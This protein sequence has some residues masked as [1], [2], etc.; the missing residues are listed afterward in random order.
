MFAFCEWKS[1]N[2]Q[3]EIKDS[4]WILI[5]N[6]MKK[7][8][9]IFDVKNGKVDRKHGIKQLFGIDGD[10]NKSE[11]KQIYTEQDDFHD[12][13]QQGTDDAIY[14]RYQDIENLGSDI[15]VQ[16]NVEFKRSNESKLNPNVLHI[17][18]PA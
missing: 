13:I 12:I 14:G 4:E 6:I 3:K 10:N 5:N 11:L 18:G 17:G 9:K 2:K 7:R 8:K 1:D 16:D 15:Q